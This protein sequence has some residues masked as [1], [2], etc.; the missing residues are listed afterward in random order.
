MNFHPSHVQYVVTIVTV[1]LVCFSNSSENAICNVGK[2]SWKKK[3]AA[4]FRDDHHFDCNASHHTFFSY[5]N[6][7]NLGRNGRILAEK[8]K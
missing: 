4:S 1:N 8:E 3:I 7:I 6:A 5:E 2:I